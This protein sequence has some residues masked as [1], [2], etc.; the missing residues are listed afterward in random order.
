MRQTGGAID[1]A[2]GI[3]AWHIGTAVRIHRNKATLT[4]YPGRFQANVFDIALHADGHQNLGTQYRAWAI[5]RLHLDLHA[6]ASH[7]CCLDTAIDENVDT[8]F[9]QRLLPV[10]ISLS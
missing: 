10:L 5:R 1:I 4:A 2:D 8:L 3:N 7:L 9:G 6:I